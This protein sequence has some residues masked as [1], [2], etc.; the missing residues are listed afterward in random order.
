MTDDSSRAEPEGSAVSVSEED[1]MR[2]AYYGMFARVLAAPAKQDTLKLLSDLSGDE[3]EVGE[4]LSAIAEVAQQT[5]EEAA[6]DAYNLLFVGQ[7]AGGTLMPYASFYR[8]GFLYEWPLARIRE[9][10]AEIGI[11][12]AGKNGEPEDHMA[13]LCE[14]MHGL[15]TGT[16]GEPLGLERQQAF[17]DAHIGPWGEMFFNDLAKADGA[18]YLAPVGRLGAL[19]LGLERDGFQ[20]AA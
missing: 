1:Q 15:I 8:T 3:S 2:A 19:F 7:G 5:D 6:E 10:M 20:M 17:F 12:H 18:G 11:G 4:A 16:Y 9:D 13:F 14:M